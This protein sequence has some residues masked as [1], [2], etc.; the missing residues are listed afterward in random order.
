MTHRH[1]QLANTPLVEVVFSLQVESP[2]PYAL[3][4]GGVYPKIAAQYPQ[5]EETPGAQLLGMGLPVPTVAHKFAS[6]DGKG[7]VQLGPGFVLVN[8]LS[9]SSFEQFVETLRLVMG[10]YL[11]LSQM[12][13]ARRIALR[14]INRIQ[15]A[16]GLLAGLRVQSEWPTL[17]DA[18]QQSVA[19]RAVFEVAR[20]KGILGFAVASPDFGGSRLDLEVASDPAGPL[21]LDA[22]LGW[23][24]EA[25]ECI[26]RAFRASVTDE[27]YSRWR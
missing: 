22:V 23:V 7:L 4:A 10:A 13:T 1:E 17:A 19:A 5:A 27:Q 8:D 25:N 2:R 3:V 6:S 24:D 12:T 21:D 9:Y 14:Y 26:Y 16:D 18:T 11:E 15:H 20:P